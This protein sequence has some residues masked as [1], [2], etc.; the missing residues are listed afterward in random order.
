MAVFLLLR[1]ASVLF[2]QTSHLLFPCSPLP[3]LFCSSEGCGS[4]SIQLGGTIAA[5]RGGKWLVEPPLLEILEEQGWKVVEGGCNTTKPFLVA[6]RSPILLPPRLL[7][8]KPM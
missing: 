5:F 4:W 6:W 1:T 7:N 2:D 3:Y 8:T